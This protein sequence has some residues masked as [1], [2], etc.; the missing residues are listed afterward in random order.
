MNRGGNIFIDEANWERLLASKNRQESVPLANQVLFHPID[1][2]ADA[3]P[4]HVLALV[5]KVEVLVS[6]IGQVHL[7]K[8]KI[9]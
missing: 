9:R 1:Q 7:K 3:V 4:T 5:M 8:S 2:H 6:D